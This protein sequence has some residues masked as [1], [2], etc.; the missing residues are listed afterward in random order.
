V[1]AFDPDSPAPPRVPADAALANLGDRDE[2]RETLTRYSRGVDRC[3]EALV[4]SCYHDDA[5][6]ARGPFTRR[7]ADEIAAGNVR[8]HRAFSPAAL[9]TISNMIIEVYGD[10]A[11]TETYQVLFVEFTRDDRPYLRMIGGRYVDRFERRA[12]RAWR[13]AHRHATLEW[14]NELPYD[15]VRLPLGRLRRGLQTPDDASYRARRGS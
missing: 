2:I 12:D 1:S 6:D 10:E 9:H 11:L 15:E 4:R 14:V 5:V 8:N 3:D 13:I 7:G